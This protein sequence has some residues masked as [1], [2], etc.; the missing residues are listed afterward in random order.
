VAV[1]SLEMREKGE[2]MVSVPEVLR[3]LR[4]L[5]CH[6]CMRALCRVLCALLQACASRIKIGNDRLLICVPTYSE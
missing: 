6:V 4:T 5:L 2:G 3:M 1:V